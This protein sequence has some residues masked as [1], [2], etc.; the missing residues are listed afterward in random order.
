[1]RC[2]HTVHLR[3]AVHIATIVVVVVPRCVTHY[4]TVPHGCRT[5]TLPHLHLLHSAAFTLHCGPYRY[6]TP[7]VAITGPYIY[8]YDTVTLYLLIVPAPHHACCGDA[9]VHY[10]T[11][12]I[13]PLG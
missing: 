8:C 2:G 12:K 9:R 4:A 10:I 13:V 3:Y 6:R 7:T 5:H 1:V 11:D